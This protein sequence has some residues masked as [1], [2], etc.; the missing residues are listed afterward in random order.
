VKTLVSILAAV[1]WVAQATAT[2]AADKLRIAYVSPSISMSAPWLAKELGILAKYDLAAEILLITGSPRLVQALIAGDVDLAFAGVT[3]L[4]R[5]RARGAEVAILGATANLSGQK[6][7]V[8]RNSKIRRLEDVKG[9]TIG[10]SQYCSEAD[11]FA[12][13]ALM[14]VGLRPD[15]DVT[16]LQLGGHPQVAAAMAAAKLEAGVLGGL[17]ALT[18][19]RSGARVIT[20]AIDL[21]I[22]SPSGTFAA[23]RGTI[24]RKRSV[25]ER[26]M[27]SFVEATHY[28]KTNRSGSLALLQKYLGG[29]SVEEATYL[30][31][32][33]VDLLEALPA[34][35][36]KALQAV[37]EREP[38]PKVKSLAIADFTDASFFK[39]IEKSGWI[40]QLYRK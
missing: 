37:L 2:V 4:T 16:F 33:Q 6:F 5:A 31:Q 39:E 27:R 34:P 10:V 40:E 1:V 18:A 30:Y 35:N 19:E 29:L 3:A 15:K 36:E 20:T 12:R 11:T 9:A 25:V 14:K 17:A 7:M 23:M 13:N 26:L 38:D 24:Q 32:E 22:L 21:N 28:L 8:S